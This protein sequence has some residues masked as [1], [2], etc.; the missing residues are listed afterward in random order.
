MEEMDKLEEEENSPLISMMPNFSCEKSQSKSD[1]QPTH[2]HTE[3][4]RN[5][6]KRR[7]HETMM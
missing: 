3:M 7:D 2:Y 1:K 6:Q 5:E 4:D